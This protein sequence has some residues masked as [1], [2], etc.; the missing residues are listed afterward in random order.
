MQKSNTQQNKK[1]K[2]HLKQSSIPTK[3][4][5]LVPVASTV[6]ALDSLKDTAVRSTLGEGTSREQSK[7]LKKA[8]LTE[9]VAKEVYN[10]LLFSQSQNESV[11]EIHEELQKE[12]GA[13]I[14]FRYQAL[15]NKVL[16]QEENE[17]GIRTLEGQ[18]REEILARLWQITLDKV[19][20]TMHTLSDG[21]ENAMNIKKSSS[22]TSSYSASSVGQ[23]S[24][25]YSAGSASQ[26]QSAQGAQNVQAASARGDVISVSNE[27]MLRTEALKTAMST[28][29]IRQE[30]IN[31]IKDRIASG[32]YAIDTKKLAFNLLK[33][34][35]ILLH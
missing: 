4:E 26:V 11:K 17:Q 23:S 27:G 32:T 31:A 9:K 18:E 12:L 20:N 7:D 35:T 14:L 34:E 30:K 25:S 15:A 6:N 21:K 8:L 28:S 1:L 24:R 33:D 13:T 3:E 10:N 2:E 16:V 5:R 19:Q 22:S 29:D